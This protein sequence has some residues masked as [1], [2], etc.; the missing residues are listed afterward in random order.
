MVFF[1]YT[2][3]QTYTRITQLQWMWLRIA[4]QNTTA[5]E[6]RMGAGDPSLAEIMSKSFFGVFS[7]AEQILGAHSPGSKG[8][9]RMAAEGCA[10]HGNLSPRAFQN[11][12]AAWDTTNFTTAC[13]PQTV[14]ACWLLWGQTLELP[15]HMACPRVSPHAN[16][17]WKSALTCFEGK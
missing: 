9:G 15:W 3:N 16:L 4:S 14:P 1:T 7:W 8:A 11:D 17:T 10:M 5:G 13:S 2:V 6:G 12:A